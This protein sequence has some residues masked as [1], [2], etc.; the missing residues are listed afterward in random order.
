[1]TGR[2]E[3]NVEE[4]FKQYYKNKFYEA[5]PKG[6]KSMCLQKSNIEWQTSKSQNP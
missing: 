2:E 1:M 6:F 3:L 5:L 4:I